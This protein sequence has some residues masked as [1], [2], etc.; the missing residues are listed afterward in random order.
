M[1]DPQGQANK[2]IKAM[3]M[4]NSLNIIRPTSSNF[5]NVL[6]HAITSGQPVKNKAKT[7]YKQYKYFIFAGFIRKH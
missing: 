3:E 1:I 5:V 2:W 6:K 7:Y 4:D